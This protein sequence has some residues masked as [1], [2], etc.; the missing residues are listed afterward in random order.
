MAK[1]LEKL[2]LLH[3]NDMH[4]DFLAEDVDQKLVG[5]VSRLSGYINKVYK[6]YSYEFYGIRNDKY[7]FGQFY[8][9]YQLG[10]GENAVT[11]TSLSDSVACIQTTGEGIEGTVAS[12]VTEW[13]PAAAE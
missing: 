9:T 11:V 10:D 7:R 12:G 8:I 1:N 5:G 3:S 13:T 2:V 4:G 6:H